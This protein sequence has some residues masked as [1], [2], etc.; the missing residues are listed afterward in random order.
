MSEL[1]L[2]ESITK[3]INKTE[4]G[5][6]TDRCLKTCQI[7]LCIVSKHTYIVKIQR[8]SWSKNQ[9]QKGRLLWRDW[10]GMEPGRTM[11]SAVLAMLYFFR[12][13]E[14]T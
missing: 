11:G 12:R 14:V 7:I 10:R 3:F 4:G 13:V 9:S 6:A 8:N 5:K 2:Y 1:E